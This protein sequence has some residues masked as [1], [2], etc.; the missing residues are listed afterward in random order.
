[1]VYYFRSHKMDRING[2]D[3]KD[4]CKKLQ[5]KLFFCFI[6]IN[7]PIHSFN[8]VWELNVCLY[9]IFHIFGP[10]FKSSHF[11]LDSC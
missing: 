1:M 8:Y 9:Q 5:S 3:I 4:L 10:I 6:L 7:R 2:L 11:A